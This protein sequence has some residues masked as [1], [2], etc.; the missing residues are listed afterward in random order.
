MATLSTRV[1]AADPLLGAL[2]GGGIGAAIGNSA[3]HRNGA[4][5]GGVLGAIVGSSI[6]ADA[7]RYDRGYDDRGY[8]EG[9][10]YEPSATYYEPAPRY[11]AAPAPVY[12]GAPAYYGPSYYPA[13]T[14][15]IGSGSRYYSR[16]GYRDG[17]RGDRRWR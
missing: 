7:N 13:A 15:V 2:I 4:A 5:V 14:I 9:G 12:Y 10:Y 16:G 11:Y 3:H 1:D 17:H 8:S 6:A